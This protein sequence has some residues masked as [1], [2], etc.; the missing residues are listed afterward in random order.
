MSL[1]RLRLEK[2]SCENGI[3]TIDADQARHL[4]LVRRCRAGA[5]VEGLLSGEKVSLKIISDGDSVRAEEISREAAPRITPELH[6]L[7]AVLK[8]DQFDSALRFAAE[9]GV[10]AVHLIRCERSVPQYSAAKTEEKMSRWRKVLDE[11][12][13]QAGSPRAPIL[14]APLQVSEFDF[15]SLPDIRL[16]ALLDPDARGLDEVEFS[17]SLVVAI[18]PEG[19]WSAAE[20]SLLLSNGFVPVSLSRQILRASTAVAV[21]CGAVMLRGVA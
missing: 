19:D 11:G 5:L 8:N 21:A 1:P 20:T 13:K 12:T 6:L 3:W 9:T 15:A 16:A 18:G 7:L 4:V 10:Y 2:C 17:E 14:T